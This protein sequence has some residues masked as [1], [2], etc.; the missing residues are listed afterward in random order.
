MEDVSIVRGIIIII[1][2]DYT[3]NKWTL[4]IVPTASIDHH[5]MVLEASKTTYVKQTPLE[6][7]EQNCL[8]NGAT[9]RGRQHASQ[10]LLHKK[11]KVPIVIREHPTRYAFPTQS[12]KNFSCSWIIAN[13]IIH[14]DVNKSTNETTFPTTIYFKSKQTLHLEE[15]TYQIK[16][17]F[18]Q[19]LALHQAL[20][21]G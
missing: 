20:K 8:N 4:A 18:E 17:Q 5:A 1:K 6:I 15:S 3:I 14:I 2:E 21:N 7:I 19:T 9:F 10:Q 11:Q 12:P 13:H 16:Q